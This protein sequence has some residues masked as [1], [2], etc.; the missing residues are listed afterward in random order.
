M[1]QRLAKFE[2]YTVLEK[3]GAAGEV[4]EQPDDGNGGT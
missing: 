2:P 4:A 1:A 3:I